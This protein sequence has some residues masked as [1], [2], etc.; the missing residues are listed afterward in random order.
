MRRSFMP[1]LL[2]FTVFVSATAVCRAT[3]DES[4]TDKTLVVWAAPADLKQSGG[5]ALTVNDTT[6]DHF[7][8]VVF[9]ELA[10]RVWMPGSNGFSR[11][12][13]KQ[14][15]W[16]KEGAAT[17]RF[18]QMAIVYR[19]REIT[20]YRNGVFY[21]GYTMNGQPFAFGIR[22]A[23]L[24]GPRHLLKNVACFKGRIRDAR[25][26]DKPLDQASIAAMQPGE[27]VEGVEPWAWW[28]FAAT[29]TYDKAGRFNKVKISGGA[30]IED[31]CL[32][33]SGARPAMLA[34]ID[35]DEGTAE[36]PSRWSNRI[37]PKK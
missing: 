28:D 35:S 31:G 17:D 10:P 9:A 23:I 4:L 1:T 8:G 19:G 36:I 5:S 6:A 26:Y 32:V 16:P 3:G 2:A 7:D 25:I 14:D 12:F 13:K 37:H 27:P 21:A 20:V 24:F 11:T 34:T 22:T 29:G 18:V 30:R 15:D 33:L